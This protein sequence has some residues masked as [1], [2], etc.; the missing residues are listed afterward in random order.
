[1]IKKIYKT[2]L[3]MGDYRSANQNKQK[4]FYSLNLTEGRVFIIFVSI[5]ALLVITFFSLFLIISKVTGSSKKNGN[6][7]TSNNITDSTTDKEYQFSFYDELSGSEIESKETTELQNEVLEVAETKR[8]KT[9]ETE[10]K[11]P[12]IVLDD[13]EI[14]YSSKF[15]KENNVSDNAGKQKT[16]TTIKRV[17]SVTKTTV[18]QTNSAASSNKRYVVQLGS[19][20]NKATADSITEFYKKAGY[21]IYLQEFKKDGKLFYRLRVGPF[22][23]KSYAE[24]YLSSLK[25]SKYGKNSYLSIIYI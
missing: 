15:R 17:V 7:V 11:E 9:I 22:K 13:S 4:S 1:L 14:L 24:N 2:E 20:Q 18:K 23:D 19:F 21:P 8:D 12:N 5:V 3:D 25:K 16:T 10:V 6:V